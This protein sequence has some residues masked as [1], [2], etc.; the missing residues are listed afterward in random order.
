MSQENTLTHKDMI[1]SKSKN[2]TY[3]CTNTNYEMGFYTPSQEKGCYGLYVYPNKFLSNVIQATHFNMIN[4][5]GELRVSKENHRY[6]LEQ[7]C[8]SYDTIFSAIADDFVT[9]IQNCFNIYIDLI[10]KLLEELVSGDDFSA[11]I[12]T[13][14]TLNSDQLTL[15]ISPYGCSINV[16]EI[17]AMTFLNQ[18]SEK[19]IYGLIYNRL[20]NE[21][22]RFLVSIQHSI[23]S[24]IGR[25]LAK[26][27]VES[28]VIKSTLYT[29]QSLMNSLAVCM[30]KECTVSSEYLLTQ[31]R[32]IPNYLSRDEYFAIKG[33]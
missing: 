7:I 26:N 6:Y 23:Q 13:H 20:T 3:D 30:E 12:Y 24:I 22:Y 5:L 1:I 10:Y 25:Y 17:F 11:L 32:T 19:E 9:H 18:L 15:Y 33:M 29:I 28:D 4:Y 2:N 14:K 16:N 27:Y 31:I 21:V 8:D